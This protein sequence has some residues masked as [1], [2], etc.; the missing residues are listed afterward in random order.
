MARI[1]DLR[2][3]RASQDD[4]GWTLIELMAAM[5][6]SAVAAVLVIP[7]LTTVTTVTS[8]TN[9]TAASTAQARQILQQLS[10]DIGSAT[11][12]NICFPAAALATPPT[13]TCTSVQTSGYPLVVL[14]K[15]NGICSWFQWNVNASNQLT[16][17]SAP[18]GAGA[19]STT[20]PLTSSL[21][22]TSSPTLFTY[23]TTNSLVNIQLVLRGA[24]G[25]AGSAA[26]AANKVGAQTINVQTSV[27]LFSTTQSAAA[28]SC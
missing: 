19:W 27:G 22:N 15:V 13:S 6:I 14:S 18:K 2:R 26:V 12:A 21:V 3:R 4:G 10:S 7:L 1:A 17:Q 24:T 11:T 28:G 8:A 23:D 25:T 5:A 20:V 16:Q 9:S